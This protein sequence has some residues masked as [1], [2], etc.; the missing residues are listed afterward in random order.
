LRGFADV[1]HAD[2]PIDFSGPG[3]GGPV[4]VFTVTWNDP[5]DYVGIVNT[6]TGRAL[7]V[8]GAAWLTNASWRGRILSIDLVTDNF[9]GSSRSLLHC[10]IDWKTMA[11]LRVVPYGPLSP[12]E[13]TR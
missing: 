4:K 10:E 8:T 3:K 11:V 1:S 6:R 12:F 9:V 2:R 5:G 7:T 13:P